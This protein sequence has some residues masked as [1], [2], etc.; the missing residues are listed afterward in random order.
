MTDIERGIFDPL[1]KLQE[2]WLQENLLRMI[3]EHI[4]DNNPNLK[5]LYLDTNGIIAVGPTVFGMINLNEWSLFQTGC[6][7][8]ET[9]VFKNP[10]IKKVLNES[11]CYKFY[12]NLMEFKNVVKH[13]PEENYVDLSPNSKEDKITHN[14]KILCLTGIILESFASLILL[15]ILIARKLKKYQ[16][17]EQVS[18]TTIRG[19]QLIYADLDL[20]RSSSYPTNEAIYA[21]AGCQPRSVTRDDHVIYSDLRM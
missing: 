5:I 15:I 16:E 3:P 6:V 4:F 11:S 20:P 12:D 14:F 7:T 19:D 9:H 8:T 13:L 1:I 2:L 18:P 17:E 21:N 10:Q